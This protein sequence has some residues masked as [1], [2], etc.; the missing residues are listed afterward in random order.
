MQLNL[1]GFSLRILPFTTTPRIDAM[2][3]LKLANA[4]VGAV[5]NSLKENPHKVY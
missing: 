2:H 5:D 3:F 1:R 4:R